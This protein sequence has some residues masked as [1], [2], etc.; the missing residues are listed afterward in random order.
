[1]KILKS[2]ERSRWH[3]R[4]AMLAGSLYAQGTAKPGVLTIGFIPRKIR[5]RWCASR[6][7][8]STSSRSTPE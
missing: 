7:R 6:K 3:V 5:A 8:F 4:P 2:Q 1:M